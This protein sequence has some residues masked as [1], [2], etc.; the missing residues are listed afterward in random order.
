MSMNERAHSLW[1]ASRATGHQC[2]GTLPELIQQTLN[3]LTQIWVHSKLQHTH[4]QKTKNTWRKLRTSSLI[5][6]Q[7]DLTKVTLNIKQPGKI[8]K[9]FILQEL[10]TTFVCYYK[11]QGKIHLIRGKPMFTCSWAVIRFLP[12]LYFNCSYLC[13]NIT[14]LY[15]K[16]G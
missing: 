1:K 11:N 16:P 12:H 13:I 8:K 6:P 5:K 2:R 9:K 3:D 14:F 10:N 7:F 4:Q 15:Q